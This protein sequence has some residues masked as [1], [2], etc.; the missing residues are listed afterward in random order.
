MIVTG[1]T[2][3]TID[4]FREI[5]AGRSFQPPNRY[6]ISIAALPFMDASIMYPES[7]IL[8]EHIVNVTDDTTYGAVRS[9]PVGKRVAEV[10]MSFILASNWQERIIFEKWIRRAAPDN[11]T[12]SALPYDSIVTDIDIQFFGANNTPTRTL[13][14]VE[15]YPLSLVPVNF[16]SDATGYVSFQVVFHVR[17]SIDIF[18]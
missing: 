13:Q 1:Q 14:L 3:P 5:V 9:V 10:M 8:P 18:Y 7:I 16:S 12:G 6:L 15:A 17:D 4:S 11:I 2:P